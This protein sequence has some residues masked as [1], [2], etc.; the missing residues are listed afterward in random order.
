LHPA[1]NGYAGKRLFEKRYQPT[2]LKFRHPVTDEVMRLSLETTDPA[3][4]KLSVRRLSIGEA[5]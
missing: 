4:L 5:K 1:R 3:G 2:W